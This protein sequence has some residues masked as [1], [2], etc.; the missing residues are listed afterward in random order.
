MREV[1]T[2]SNIIILW[3][4]YYHDL[5]NLHVTFGHVPPREIWSRD[6]IQIYVDCGLR[7]RLFNQAEAGIL[8]GGITI[9]IFI[10]LMV[11]TI[12]ICCNDGPRDPPV[13]FFYLFISYLVQIWYNKTIF[14]LWKASYRFL[15]FH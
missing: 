8:V 4:W 15:F 12:T 11:V 2:W 5:F 6:H 13:I 14:P 10:E 7:Q 9:R 1:D 3:G